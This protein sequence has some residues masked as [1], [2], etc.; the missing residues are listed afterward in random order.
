MRMN[1]LS[2]KNENGVDLA[3]GDDYRNRHDL[4]IGKEKDGVQISKSYSKHQ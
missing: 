3:V 4:E 2:I 1:R